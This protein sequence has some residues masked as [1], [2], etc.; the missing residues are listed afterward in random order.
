MCMRVSVDMG[1]SA[2]IYILTQRRFAAFACEEGFILTVKYE[3]E[4][5]LCLSQKMEMRDKTSACA[6]K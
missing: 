6:K 3:M 1:L 2:Y 5:S 4:I